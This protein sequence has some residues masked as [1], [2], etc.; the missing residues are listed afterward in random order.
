MKTKGQRH[1]NGTKRH[2]DNEYD[3]GA[4]CWTAS[5]SR[6]YTVPVIWKEQGLG[7][8]VRT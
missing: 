7:V 8:P 5:K 1:I 4:G 2:I 3:R 6:V